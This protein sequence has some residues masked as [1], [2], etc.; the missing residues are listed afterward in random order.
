MVDTV[1]WGIIGCGNV[2]E[3]KSGPAF[4]KAENSSLV[5]VMRRD[6]TK[7]KDFAERHKV[8]K[9]YIDADLLINDPDVNMIYVATPPASHTEYAIKALQA[10][11]SVYV[12][13]PMAMNY[14]ECLAMNQAAEASKQKL[15]VAFYRRA[16]PYFLKVKELLENNVIGKVLTVDIRYFRPASLFDMDVREQTWRVNREI[17]GEGYFLDLAPHTLDILDF[18][19]GEIVEAKGYNKN[20]AGFYDVSDTITAIMQFKSGILGSG[21]WSYVTSLQAQ[22]DSITIIGTEGKIC[23]NTFSFQPIILINRKGEKYFQ[24]SHPQHIQQPLI[25]S[26]VDELRG[27][28][29]C[30]STG[31]SGARTSKVMDQI[32]NNYR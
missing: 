9:Y 27:V 16:L 22:E 25:Q 5:A 7:V 13:K 8:E 24:T 15:Y 12:E 17:A 21:S 3:K 4:Y 29:I 10:G 14:A 23:F 6:E 20:M 19:L 11:K 30:P 28:G 32:F 18:L 31:V 2:C 26:I 1:K